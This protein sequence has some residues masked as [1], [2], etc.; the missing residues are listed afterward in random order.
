M[1]PCGRDKPN[2][3][4]ACGWTRALSLL[5]IAL[6]FLM[7]ACPLFADNFSQSKETSQEAGFKIA[8]AASLRDPLE[9]IARTFEQE[10]KVKIRISYGA[11]GSLVTQLIHGAPFD[12]FLSADE[13]EMKRLIAEGLAD[14]PFQFGLGRIVLWVPNDSHLNIEKDQMQTL[15]NHSIKKIAIANPIHAPYGRA[16]ISALK[17]FGV[18]QQIAPKLIYGADMMQALQFV[19]SGGADIGILAYSIVI[20]RGVGDYFLIPDHAHPPIEHFGGILKKSRSQVIVKK[21]VD[22]ILF[23]SGKTILKEYGYTD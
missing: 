15:L 4:Y 3:Q 16:A 18:D 21:F 23:G 2:S 12:L 5:A 7:M 14:T 8:A 1:N 20:K 11:T 9:K 13:N 22:A 19:E 10:N 6:L 17:H